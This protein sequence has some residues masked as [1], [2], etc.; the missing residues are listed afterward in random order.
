MKAIDRNCRRARSCTQAKAFRWTTPALAL[1][2]LLL[3]CPAFAAESMQ[4]PGLP[5]P[6][7]AAQL[8][9]AAG[10]TQNATPAAESHTVLRGPDSSLQLCVTAKYTTGQLRDWTGKVT[11]TVA[12]EGIVRVDAAGTVIP[13][14]DGK[15]T[16]T[17][18]GAEGLSASVAITVQDFDNPPP[19]NFP[20]QITP[21]FTKLGCNS[22]GCH[23]K[24]GG[25]NG[26][27]LSLL[28]FEPEKDY[29]YLV[30]ESRGRRVFPGAPDQSLL[31]LKPTN[32]M[33][34]GGGERMKVDSR[35]YR[36]IYRW[37]AQGM[38]Y[39]RE[40]DPTLASI[41]VYPRAR[42]LPPDGRQQL[43]VIARY[44]DGR[45]EDITSTTQLEPNDKE[46]AEITNS[47]VVK[48][49]GRPGDV[50]VM[51]RYQGHVSVF[52]ATAPV[53]APVANLPTA[54]NFVD[55]LAFARFRELGLP[56]SSLCDDSTFIRRVSLDMAGRLPTA[57]E[58][59]QFLAD[60]DAAKRDNYIDR[61]LASAGY[62]DFFA[63]KWS[64]I[65]RN[66][67]ERETYQRGN[68]LFYEWL[69]NGIES[70][71]PFDQFVRDLLTAS[72][73]M[74]QSPA[75]NWYRQSDETSKEVE[76][77]AQVFLGVRIGCAKC[78]HHPFERW[79]QN[80]YYS[81]TAFFSRVGRKEGSG[82]R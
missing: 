63:E 47:G 30:E 2:S 77:V 20:N 38:P 45:T 55:E 61:L 24:S 67:R 12:P 79:S 56:P 64:A 22:G 36:L 51:A 57:A 81:M 78:H 14:H 54:R 31:L 43:L 74:A 41:D 50:A 53:G 44:S 60:N 39:G 26:F 25:Q 34:H 72:G 65:L 37:I 75:V 33:A 32:H 52:S 6:G 4:F 28:G 69:R 16:I 5:D 42:T 8:L 23:G 15:A 49:S 80:D 76:D 66:R 59:R 13:L 62:A 27:R 19:I 1:V 29:R 48:M 71:K 46:L 3:A 73:D 35:D 7:K 11:Y 82:R 68:Y 40:S 70:N 10:S 9:I 18:A 17:A 21:I 58:A